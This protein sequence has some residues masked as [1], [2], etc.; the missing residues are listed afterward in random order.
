MSRTARKLFKRKESEDDT[1][2][3]YFKIET[4]GSF[5]RND[6]CLLLPLFRL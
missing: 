5:M 1:F 4:I 6:F 3:D 2:I